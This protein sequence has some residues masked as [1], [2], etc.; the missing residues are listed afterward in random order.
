MLSYVIVLVLMYV[1]L[2][3]LSNVLKLDFDDFVGVMFGLVCVVFI[4]F[5]VNIVIGIM[6]GFVILVIGCIIFGEFKKLNIGIVIIVIVLVVF[7][8]LGLVI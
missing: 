1:G 8:V 5:I 2:L 6:L 3:M 4:V 7:Y